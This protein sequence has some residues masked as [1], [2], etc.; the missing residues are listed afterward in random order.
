MVVKTL[1]VQSFENQMFAISQVVKITLITVNILLFA[2][3]QLSAQSARK[4][5]ISGRITGYGGEG[6]AA[7]TVA[8]AGKPTG[9]IADADGYFK[10]AVSGDD[11]IRISYTGYQPLELYPEETE[12]ELGGQIVLK[13]G[14]WLQEVVIVGQRMIRDT[15]HCCYCVSVI[16][17]APQT[18][19]ATK[20]ECKRWQYYPNPTTTGVTVQTEELEGL[21]TVLASDGRLVSRQTVTDLVTWVDLSG[22]PTGMY[23]LNYEQTDW[24]QVI[25]KVSVVRD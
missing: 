17:P 23:V 21:I 2:C 25:G 1:V 11:V 8:L 6:L 7:A 15:T 16:R 22:L 18:L 10:L 5:V 20:P 14:L 3:A 9:T 12:Y 4:H 24:A 19:S 13:E